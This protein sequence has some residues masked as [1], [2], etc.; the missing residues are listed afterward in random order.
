MSRLAVTVAKIQQSLPELKRDGN[1]VLSALWTELVHN[2]KSTSRASGVLSQIEFIPQL[3]KRLQ[4][5]PDE[6]I[7]EMELVRNHSMHQELPIA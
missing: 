5:N 7:K 4:E 6:V 2:D 1:T 3:S